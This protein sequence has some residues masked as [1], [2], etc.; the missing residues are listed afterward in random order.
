MSVYVCTYV[1]SY[2]QAHKLKNSEA[3]L[4]KSLNALPA[5]KRILLSGNFC[6]ICRL[7]S[8]CLSISTSALACF[9]SF[10]TSRSDMNCRA[11][12]SW[13]LSCYI[14]WSTHMY[15][16][17][18]CICSCIYLHIYACVCVGT[19]MQNELTEFY[20]MVSFCNP[21]VL[22]SPAEFRKRYTRH[23]YHSCC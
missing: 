11:T 3:G 10:D 8:C 9:V 21:G 23:T 20:N 15:L 19:P 16:P 4:T 2:E 7:L 6:T 22:G 12:L 1:R 5:K 18:S 13:Y 14:V 17:T